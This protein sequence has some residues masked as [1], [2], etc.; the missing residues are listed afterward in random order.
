MKS[1]TAATEVSNKIQPL[2]PLYWDPHLSSLP[3]LQTLDLGNKPALRKTFEVSLKALRVHWVTGSLLF[4]DSS[5][6]LDALAQD[7]SL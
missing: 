1:K 5:F 2:L 6:L 4:Q 3:S 7:S